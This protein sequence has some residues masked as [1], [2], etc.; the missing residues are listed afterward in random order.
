MAVLPDVKKRRKNSGLL[1]C[2]AALLLAFSCN[3]PVAREAFMRTP[4]EMGAYCFSFDFEPD[5]VD[6]D[7]FITARFDCPDSVLAGLGDIPVRM[8]L[9]SPELEIQ[10][11]TLYFPME[12]PA[13]E[14]NHHKDYRC[15]YRSGVHGQ[16]HWMLTITPVRTMP[17]DF[18]GFGMQIINTEYGKR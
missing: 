2:A 9:F 1:I 3:P 6:Y 4:S 8:A 5:T 10:D 17:E 13:A 11:D 16:G 14:S 12:S 15:L 18:L 7:I